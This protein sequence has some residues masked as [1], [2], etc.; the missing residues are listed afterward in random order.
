MM[1]ASRGNI[2][3]SAAKSS[4]KVHWEV[5]VAGQTKDGAATRWV[6]VGAARLLGHRQGGSTRPQGAQGRR[7]R[8]EDRRA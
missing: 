1:A 2:F 3:R 7:A 8:A 5:T 6:L 4:E